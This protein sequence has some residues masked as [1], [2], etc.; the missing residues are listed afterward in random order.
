MNEFWVVDANERVT[1][2]H[3]RPSEQGW[4]S[5][6]RKGPDELLTLAALPSFSMKLRDA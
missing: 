4:A 6:V 3:Q 5:V 1:F 2:I